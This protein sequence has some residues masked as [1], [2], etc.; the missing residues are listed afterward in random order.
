MNTDY[1][2]LP[3]KFPASEARLPRTTAGLNS[4]YE[5]SRPA[6]PKISSASRFE[7]QTETWPARA[8]DASFSGNVT[9]TEIGQDRRHGEG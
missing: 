6:I 9:A 8:G 2:A 5:E 7:N 4:S 1:A 3:K